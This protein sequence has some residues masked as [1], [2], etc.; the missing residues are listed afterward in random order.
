MSHRGEFAPFG[1]DHLAVLAALAAGAAVLI[2]ARRRLMGRD[3]RWVRRPVAVTLAANELV[4][5]G[6]A[7]RQ[8]SVGL[9]LQ[10]CDLALALTVWAL[11]SLR[12]RVSELAYF[13]GLGG[14]LQAILTPDLSQ[15]FGTYWWT[16]FFLSHTGIV[17]SV[18]YLA[19]TGRVAPTQRS[20]WRAWGWA[21]VYLA[22]AGT[23]N[24]ALG[25]N[26]GYLARK[27]AH[28]S[29]LDAFGPWP[30]YV[31]AME[32]VAVGFFYLYYAPFAGSKRWLNR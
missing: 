18:V 13:W 12:P 4:S 2:V 1:S 11:L 27:P 25:T 23:V 16:Q 32:V 30:F 10:L 31:L 6:V 21:N 26:Y 22:V 29:L 17:L 19:V 3:D 8:G 20:V 28:P 9:P 5:Y 15:G 24:W 14:S 7:L